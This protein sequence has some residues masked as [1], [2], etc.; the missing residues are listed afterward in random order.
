MTFKN[1]IFLD[2]T[3]T[4]S[5]ITLMGYHIFLEIIHEWVGLCLFVMFIF[6]Q[7]I[8]KRWYSNLNKGKYKNIRLFQTIINVLLIVTTFLAVVSGMTMSKYIFSF[9]FMINISREVHMITTSWLFILLGLHAGMHVVMISN[10]IKKNELSLVLRRIMNCI[11][12]GS[13]LYGGIVFFKRGLYK[14]MF[15][16][17]SFQFLPYG[18]NPIIYFI[19]YICLF[20]CFMFIA[21]GIQ[22]LMK[23]VTKVHADKK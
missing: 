12:L 19:D 17:E 5:M 13:S 8:N 11:L 21:Y 1:K 18:E 14:N 20:L 16:L 6:H 4:I 7:I 22:A 2:I 9:Q 15:A 3:M 23:K 10:F